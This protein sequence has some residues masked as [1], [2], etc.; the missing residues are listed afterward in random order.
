MTIPDCGGSSGN[1]QTLDPRIVQGIPNE[2]HVFQVMACQSGLIFGRNLPRNHG[3]ASVL[4][5]VKENAN[6][7]AV[8]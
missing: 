1:A 7:S 2:H 6:C 8:G 3:V 5:Q 4:V